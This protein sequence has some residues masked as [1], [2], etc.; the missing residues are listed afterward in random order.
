MKDLKPCPFCGNEVRAVDDGEIGW[1]ACTSDSACFN[2][3]LLISFLPSKIEQAIDLWNTRVYSQDL[4]DQVK[5][6]KTA[7]ESILNN[8]TQYANATV[9]RMAYIAEEA[10]EQVRD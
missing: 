2:S 8:K 4:E 3:G 5:V 6:M 9:K 7:L 10:L 1:I